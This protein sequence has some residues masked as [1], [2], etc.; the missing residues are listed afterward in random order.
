[1]PELLLGLDI[2]TTTLTA[3]IFTAGGDLLGQAGAPVR[4]TTPQPGRVEQDAQAI[5]RSTRA[6]IR[7]A[8]AKAG[9]QPSDLAGIGITSQ[10]TSALFWDRMTEKPLTLLMTTS[11]N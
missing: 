11:P 9:R 7:D 10:R 2:G 4:T 5:W 8:L 6:V 3:C 1:M